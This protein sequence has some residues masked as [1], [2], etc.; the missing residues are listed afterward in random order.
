M[1]L[2]KVAELVEVTIGDSPEIID[3]L[4]VRFLVVIGR[5][6]LIGLIDRTY[7]TYLV[8]LKGA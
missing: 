8:F 4:P 5:I 6:G 2:K 1:C 7:R 3:I